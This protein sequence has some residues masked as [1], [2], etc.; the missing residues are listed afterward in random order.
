MNTT[1][2][3]LSYD[4]ILYLESWKREINLA[5]RM[6]RLQDGLERGLPADEITRNLSG[7]VNVYVK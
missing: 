2:T 4:D 6:N 7:F 5:N 1:H 3:A